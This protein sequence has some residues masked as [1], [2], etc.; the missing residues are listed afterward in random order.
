MTA[1]FFAM[2]DDERRRLTGNDGR[3]GRSTRRRGGRRH[4]DPMD[5]FVWAC[6]AMMGGVIVVYCVLY[7]RVAFIDPDFE[8][9]PG[10]LQGLLGVIP[11]TTTLILLRKG[12]NGD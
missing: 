1:L 9:P 2:P 8:V 10:A 3:G 11:I 12:K 4:G 5:A 6:I 7:L